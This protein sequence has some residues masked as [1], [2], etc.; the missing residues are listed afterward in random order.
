MSELLREQVSA[1]MDGELP[2][3]ECELLLKRVAASP[4]LAGCWHAFHLIGDALRG[5]IAPAGAQSVAA[6]VEHA[7][8]GRAPKRLAR[9][10][11][12]RSATVAAGVAVIGLAGLIGALV[13]RQVGGGQVLVPGG[14]G[15]P[16]MHQVQTQVDWQQTPTPVRAELNR[17][18]LMHDPYGAGTMPL[19]GAAAHGAAA[20]TGSAAVSAGGGGR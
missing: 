9:W 6:R 5:E 1:F 19:A 12:R 8:E 16:A 4:E 13:S 11:M 15:T 18:M 3:E 20:V 17:Y 2:G 7:L 14:S 10:D